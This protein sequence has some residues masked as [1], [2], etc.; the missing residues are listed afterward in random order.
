MHPGTS[1]DTRIAELEAELAEANRRIAAL[2]SSE[3]HLRGTLEN[4]RVGIANA[5]LDGRL[6]EVNAAYCAMLGFSREELLGRRYLE[7]THPADRERDW[8]N[9]EGVRNSA[10]DEYTV[11]KRYVHKQGHAVWVRVTGSVVRDE[12]GAPRHVVAVVE[13]VSDRRAAVDQLSAQRALLQEVVDNL[14]G[15]VS[16]YSPDLRIQFVNKPFA[17]R[18]GLRTEDLEGRTVAEAFP[19][20][21]FPGQ[22]ESV[23]A[24]LGRLAETHEPWRATGFRSVFVDA[25]GNAHE[26]ATDHAVVPVFDRDG[27]F[28]G[29]LSLSFDATARVALE[30][31]LR[32]RTEERDQER[33]MLARII[34]HVPA[35]IGYLDRD[36]IVRW[37]NPA[38]E[39]TLRQPASFYLGR[40]LFEAAPAQREQLEAPLRRVLETGEPLHMVAYPQEATR[41]GQVATRFWDFSSVPVF[42]PDGAA[43]GILTFAMDVTERVEH[44][45]QREER[46]EALRDTNAQLRQADRYKDEFLSVISHE[47]RTPLN[48]ITGF[49]S[50]L[51]DALF[52]PLNERQHEA[53]AKIL[54]GAERMLMLVDDLLD[55]AKIQSGMLELQPAPTAYAPLVGE[56]I[57]LLQPLARNRQLTLDALIDAPGQALID[58]ARVA[59]VLSN[60]LSNAIKFSAPGG[61]IR[62]SARLQGP[63]LLTE[64]SDTGPGIRPDD[65][66]RLFTRFQQLDMS[67]TRQAGGTGLGLAICK[68]LVEAHGG[69]IGVTS[70]LGH[71][72][73]F[74]FRLPLA[75]PAEG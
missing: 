38:Y 3:S 17:A 29:S 68:A 13:D 41:D 4:A 65:L 55:Y 20:E 42:G 10:H 12:Q 45:R 7:L 70:E 44:E 28:S 19:P 62:V 57:A 8:E 64:V 15:M 59:Q 54:N 53:V 46:E 35:G 27:G 49:A 74:W 24:L 37:L 71:G 69:Q 56:T 48:F 33:A 25:E 1:S 36:L 40:S 73:T 47:L 50:I 21:T 75:G 16:Y 22:M 31:A 34:E 32:R 18:Y 23:L 6:I 66:P 52:G 58:G 67:R 51:D 39:R 26:R 43:E 30:D 63:D 60:L 5:D 9:F 11:E 72:S 14:P 61:H 2:Q